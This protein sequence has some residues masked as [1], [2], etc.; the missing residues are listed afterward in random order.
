MLEGILRQQ[1]KKEA[2][3]PHKEPK[4][5]DLFGT[6]GMASPSNRG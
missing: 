4:C 2:K 5:V 1:Q 6:S 3:Q